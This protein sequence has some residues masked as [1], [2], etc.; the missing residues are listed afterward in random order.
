MTRTTHP[1]PRWI[2]ARLD[3]R[4]TQAKRGIE[5]GAAAMSPRRGSVQGVRDPRCIAGAA[6]L[7]AVGLVGGFVAGQHDPK[8]RQAAVMCLSA[9]GAISCFDDT[10]PG[11]GE[12]HVPLD[13]A[14]VGRDAVST[15][16]VGPSAFPA[17]APAKWAQWL[18]P[19]SL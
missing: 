5:S 10:D 7:L 12:L 15:R 14:W 9:P 4:C 2:E 19:G 8:F 6:L 1:P 3:P 13:V 17:S 18:S 16:T 11:S